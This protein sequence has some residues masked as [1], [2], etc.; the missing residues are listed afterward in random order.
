[1]HTHIKLGAYALQFDL[2]ADG[3]HVEW[4]AYALIR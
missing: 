3:L 1:M 4:R 2:R